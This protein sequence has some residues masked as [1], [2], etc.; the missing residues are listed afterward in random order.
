MPKGARERRLQRALVAVFQAGELRRVREALREA[1][2]EDLIGDG[3]ECLIPSRPP[4]MRPPET[5]EVG[6][7]A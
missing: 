3:P 2:R 4:K 7:V 6:R 5:G 1:G